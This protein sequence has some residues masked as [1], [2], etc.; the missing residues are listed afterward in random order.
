MNLDSITHVYTHISWCYLFYCIIH[1]GLDFRKDYRK[2]GE[3]SSIIRCPT[4]CLSATIT[5]D[6]KTDV[7]NLM[8]LSDDVHVLAKRPDR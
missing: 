8:A 5:T 2:V 7:N 3:L 4:L 1:R 6:I